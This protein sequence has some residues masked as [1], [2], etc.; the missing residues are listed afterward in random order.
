MKFKTIALVA[1]S[2]AIAGC[3][4]SKCTGNGGYAESIDEGF[5]SLFNG[6]DL[7]GWEAYGTELWYVNDEGNMV[8]ES[9]P[10]KQ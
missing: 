8:C 7:T 10:D 5:T 4:C 3:C 9:G 1:A 2:A 6:K